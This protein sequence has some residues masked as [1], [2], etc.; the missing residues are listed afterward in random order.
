[1]LIPRV[2]RLC[3]RPEPA[4][5]G[6]MNLDMSQDE[7]LSEHLKWSGVKF[8][9]DLRGVP[10]PFVNKK[11]T[12]CQDG[13]KTATLV[14]PD[15][16]RPPRDE[17]K[18]ILRAR[19]WDAEYWCWIWKQGDKTHIMGYFGF[20][21]YRAFDP[22][23]MDW[24]TTLTC[25]S[26]ALPDI[27]KNREKI[28]KRSRDLDQSHRPRPRISK[29]H[30]LKR[31]MDSPIEFSSMVKDSKRPADRE[32]STATLFPSA[33]TDLDTLDHSG[34]PNSKEQNGRKLILKFKYPAQAGSRP[35]RVHSSL[36]SQPTRTEEG[37]QMWETFENDTQNGHLAVEHRTSTSRGPSLELDSSR[38]PTDG[39]DTPKTLDTV[40]ELLLASTESP[41]LLSG[42]YQGQDN[43]KSCLHAL[44]IRIATHVWDAGCGPRKRQKLDTTS[45]SKPHAFQ[46]EQIATNTNTILTQTQRNNTILRVC[47]GSEPSKFLSGRFG[48]CSNTGEFFAKIAYIMGDTR[49]DPDNYAE[50][51]FDWKDDQDKLKHVGVN[52][53]DQ[54]TFDE[55]LDQIRDADSWQTSSK[56]KC[57]LTVELARRPPPLHDRRIADGDTLKDFIDSLS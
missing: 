53:F 23:T 51:T 8:H 47:R 28:P 27:R 12:V 22:K 19:K 10:P 5:A 55:V 57:F 31:G 1:M 37:L 29:P 35:R 38:A 44:L 11:A 33:E 24:D 50:V 54:Q 34:L 16:L 56:T 2:Q 42:D 45:A 30:K 43:G 41:R 52:R 25:W 4:G 13:T 36:G 15:P 46:S 20:K 3:T 17:D 39:A 32:A 49:E 9:F 40:D 26:V 21:R 14:K 6:Q 18:V 7:Y 48:S